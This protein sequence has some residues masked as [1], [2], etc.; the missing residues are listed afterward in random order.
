M[1][2]SRKRDRNAYNGYVASRLSQPSSGHSSSQHASSSPSRPAHHLPKRPRANSLSGSSQQHPVIIDDDDEEEDED[3]SQEAPDASQDDRQFSYVH[4]GTLEAKIVG[5]RF[6]SGYAT[7]GEM[8]FARR[9][10]HNPYDGNEVNE[11]LACIPTDAPGY[12]KRHSSSKRTK[13]PDR[14]HT[15]RACI[16]VSSVHGSTRSLRRSSHLR[17]ER[18]L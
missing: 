1:P 9:E 15:T 3:G 16:Q 11:S 2:P 6:Y 17:R 5:C 12:R 14:P 13:H 8:A 18:L 7:E 4:Y 10:P